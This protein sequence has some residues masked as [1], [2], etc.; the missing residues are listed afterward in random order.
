M[1]H[2]ECK[3]VIGGARGKPTAR[4]GVM[5]QAYMLEESSERAQGERED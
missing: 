2:L 1:Y 3:S 4:S 5:G